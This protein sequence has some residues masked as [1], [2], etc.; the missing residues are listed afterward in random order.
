NGY[1]E[2]DKIKTNPDKTEHENG[3]ERKKQKPR[4][5]AS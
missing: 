3:K 1:Q 5:G 4:S 2:N